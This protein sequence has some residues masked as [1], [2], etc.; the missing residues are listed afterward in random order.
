[1][2]LCQCDCG[3]KK[4]ISRGDLVRTDGKA[5]KSCG[6]IKE[7]DLTGKKIGKLTVLKR[8]NKKW[9]CQC[10][11]GRQ[12][13]INGGDLIRTDGKATVSCGCSRQIDE[14]GNR[15]GKLTVLY[16]DKD[17]PIGSY[18]GVHW[19]C[20]CDCGNLVS[21]SGANLRG[22]HAIS[23]GCSKSKGEELINSILQQNNIKY[24]RE[25]TF[26]NLKDKTLLR[27]DFAI[28]NRNNDLIC[29]IE[30]QGEQHYNQTGY[31]KDL[32][33]FKSAQHRDEMKREYCLKNNIPLLE[34]KYTDFK[35]INILYLLTEMERVIKN[36]E[37]R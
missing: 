13:S 16:K 36:N 35:K 2:W 22:G 14:T 23:C 8:D 17:Y 24:Y 31:Y 27:F 28:F 20:K 6:C 4:I 5:I 21:Y 15:Y 29:L 1:M 25:Y 11:C 3:N 26:N 12:V 7:N 30:Y 34:I 33:K 37:N 19:I 32:A 9:L 10:D 18:D